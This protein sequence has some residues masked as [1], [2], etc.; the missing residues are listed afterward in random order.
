ME[1]EKVVELLKQ[2]QAE[3]RE[4]RDSCCGSEVTFRYWDGKIAGL[5]VAI[6]LVQN[7][8]VVE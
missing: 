7:E 3:A 6:R 4:N 2:K 1:A 8:S 5:E